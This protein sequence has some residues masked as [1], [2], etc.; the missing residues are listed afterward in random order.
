V[1]VAE[2]DAAG[3]AQAATGAEEAAVTATEAEIDAALAGEEDG[4]APEL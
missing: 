3:E 2:L 1:A 4:A